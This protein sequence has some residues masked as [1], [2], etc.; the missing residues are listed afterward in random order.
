[1]KL[2]VQIPCYNE[3]KTLEN[4]LK[5]IPKK[6]PGITKIE[7]QII[8]DGSSDKTIKIAEKHKVHYIVKHTGNK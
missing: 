6:V 5:T 8:D 3:E 1:M 7:T 4:V 2:I